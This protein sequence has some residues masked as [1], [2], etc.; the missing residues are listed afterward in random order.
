M[1][2]NYVKRILDIIISLIALII[3]SPILCILTVIGFFQMKGNPFFYQER[4]GKNGKIFGLI[5]FRS[6]SNAK[7]NN[8]KLLPDNVRLNTYGKLIRKLSLDELP[9]LI[10]ILKGDMS[11]VGPRPLAVQYLPYYND[12]EKRRHDVLP[13]LTGL[14]QINGRNCVNWPERFAYDIEYVENVSF[15]L[16]VKIILKTIVKVI[17]RSDITVR[18]SGEIMDFDKFRIKQNMEIQR[19]KSNV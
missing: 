8:G 5:K 1:Y 17:K 14:A 6:M 3:L 7:D 4:P 19:K 10:N 12:E 18:A 2:R 11:I 16:D 9:E 13:G 15:M